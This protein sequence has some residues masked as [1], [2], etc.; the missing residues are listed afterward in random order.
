MKY[1]LK[2]TQQ[3]F[4]DPH[5]SPDEG[6]KTVKVLTSEDFKSFEPDTNECYGDDG[7]IITGE[8]EN[9]GEDGYN[10]ETNEHHYA[11]ITKEEY[12]KYKVIIKEY[13]KLLKL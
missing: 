5:G 1:Y 3:L 13:D 6:G 4:W 2:K 11:E 10:C 9:Y 7:E 8:E 12:D